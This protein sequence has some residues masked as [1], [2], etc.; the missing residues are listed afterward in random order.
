MLHPAGVERQE[1]S[2]QLAPPARGARSLSRHDHRMR[3]KEGYNS[4]ELN[5]ILAY[6]PD[7]QLLNTFP[8]HGDAMVCLL[9]CV[10]AVQLVLG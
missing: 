9:D 8:D 1:P 2:E 7:R 10:T 3:I 6:T 4:S 5:I